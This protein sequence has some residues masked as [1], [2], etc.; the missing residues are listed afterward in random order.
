M[1]TLTQYEKELRESIKAVRK[2]NKSLLRPH[3]TSRIRDIDNEFQNKFGER[4]ARIDLT[5]L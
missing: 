5:Q 3:W 4:M 1:K 2:L